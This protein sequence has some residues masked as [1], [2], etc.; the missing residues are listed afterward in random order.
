MAIPTVERALVA[1]LAVGAAAVMTGCVSDSEGVEVGEIESGS[2]DVVSRWNQR[3]VAAAVAAQ[4]SP[5]FQTRTAAIVHVSIFDATAS[6]AGGYEVYAPGGPVPGGAS[7][8]AAASAA[9]HRALRRQFDGHPACVGETDCSAEVLDAALA[10]EMAAIPEGQAREYGNAWGIA[11]AD[12]IAELRSTDGAFDERPPYTGGPHAGEPGF[13]VPTPPGFLPGAAPQYADV[14]PWAME[15]SDQFLPH[16]P[17]ALSGRLY[18]A[19]FDEVKALGKS[20]S[21]ARTS[22]QTDAALAWTASGAVIWNG[23][24]R[25]LVAERPKMSLVERARVFALMNLAADD[26]AISVWNAKYR[27]SF[28]RPITA[29]RGAA[30]DGN[31]ATTEDPSW[32]PLLITP[33]FPEYTSGHAGASAAAAVILAF[34]FGD[35]NSFSFTTTRFSQATTDALPDRPITRSFT[36]LSA[37]LAEV[38]DARVWAGIHYRFSDQVA[39]AQGVQVAVWSLTHVLRPDP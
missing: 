15:S 38:I 8:E 19:G 30:A 1:V 26:A 4:Q 20:D 6:I 22:D 10:Q 33:P 14:T 7:A 5:G 28:W 31:P 13:W 32:L 23:I 3:A 39:A 34:R 36:R 21:S 12:R 2:G 35:R 24:A 11:A 29:I 27:H 9:A 37:A 17:P 16:G 18:A 25:Q